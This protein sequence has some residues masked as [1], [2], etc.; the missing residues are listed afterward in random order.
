MALTSGTRLGPYEILAAVGS[1]GMGE[2]YKA[3][4]GRLDRVVAVKVIS[5]HTEENRQ[6]FE[7]EAR[8]ISSL[9][10]PHICSLY[11]VGR[12]DETD[13][14][15]MEFVDGITLSER[16][17]SGPLPVAEMLRIGI[18]IAEALDAAHRYG[19]V[20]RDLKP[21]NVMLS[22][23]GVKLLDF[24]L[25]KLREEPAALG[26]DTRSMTMAEP[27][28]QKGALMG[29]FHYMAPEQWEGKDADARSDIFALGAVLYEMAA[30]RRPFDGAS[31]A[32]LV[33]AILER[34]PPEPSALRAGIPSVL[35]TVIK[36]CLAKDPEQRWQTARDVR[37]ALVWVTS[38]T[39]TATAAAE[40]T[41]PRPKPV[42][43]PWPVWA[44]TTALLVAGAVFATM[45]LRPA[46]ELPVFRN[47]TFSGRDA[48][49][50]V[51]P[52]G[53]TIAFSSRRDG[54]N[55]IWLK[56]LLRGDESPLTEGPNDF[57]PSFSPDG[58][59]ILFRR[60]AAVYR[61][62]VVG[63]QVRKVADDSL[64][65]A[66]WSPDGQRVVY[67]RRTGSTWLLETVALTGQG[68]KEI[69]KYPAVISNP[70]WSPDGK[71]VAAS[72]PGG[73][74]ALPS[75]LFLTAADGSGS[76]KLAVAAGGYTISTVCWVSDHEIVYSENLSITGGGA[77]AAGS[78]WLVRQDILNGSSTKLLQHSYS[79]SNV[80]I[81]GP[82]RI[83]FGSLLSRQ[84]LVGF[85]LSA[86]A[87]G[88]MPEVITEGSAQDRQP[89]FSPDGEWIL[90]TSNRSGDAD[91]WKLSRKSGVLRRLTDDPAHDWD[92]SFTP[93]GK[94]ILWSSNRSGGMEVWVADTE[95]AGARQVSNDGLDAENP[96]ATPDG[97]VVYTSGN[98]AHQGLWK[99]RLNGSGT[100]QLS[101]SISYFPQVSPD[102]RYV[103][104]QNV[105]Q[106][107]NEIMSLADGTVTPLNFN[108]GRCRFTPD[109]DSLV[110]L[111]RR[112]NGNLGVVMQS[113]RPT[114]S[115]AATRRFIEH[116]DLPNRP[117]S[118]G[119]SPDGSHIVLSVQEPGASV[120]E[121]AHLPG[122]EGRPVRR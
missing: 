63:G 99:V 32:A 76:R 117:E 84:N 66:D 13:Y 62:T 27:L 8:A 56:E 48:T 1:G 121:V 14:L 89:V 104:Y 20:H 108:A 78:A 100:T 110:Y 107:R 83:V 24:G 82:G 29:T 120:G 86:K 97:W 40:R 18:Q 79:I 3:R 93:D 28:T 35:D 12:Q 77:V 51:S 50:T 9:N 45:R 67:V 44:A 49:P 102:G 6:R 21:G 95:G 87:G 53:K 74:S 59:S 4:D 2:V 15:V 105:G 98:P 115:T 43:W 37:H 47:L 33:A 80:N 65:S 42:R 109:G 52:D 58:G 119:L 64:N 60:G 122:I 96:T 17:K 30:G 7:R 11:D 38:S 106:A 10:H 90:F 5:D 111:G 113:L 61:V 57:A 116:I 118:F 72:V 41:Q 68:R 101:K 25:A 19:V 81:A 70:R 23:A 75:Q 92:P 31:Q 94:Q 34:E 46:P 91:I 69:A 39:A 112:P 73:I 54:S 88:E 36:T 16:L 71:W 114:G 55:R 103:V 22:K 85:G 26:Q